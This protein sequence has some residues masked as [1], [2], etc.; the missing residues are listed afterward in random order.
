MTSGQR[1]LHL[2]MWLVL[3][4]IALV[5]LALAVA[6][7]PGVPVHDGALPGVQPQAEARQTDRD[8]EDDAEDDAG[9]GR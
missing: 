1:K 3:G 2:L 6:W 7:R 4:P 8:A 5:G 9:G